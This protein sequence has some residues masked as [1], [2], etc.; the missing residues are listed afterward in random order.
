M[1]GGEGSFMKL[2]YNRTIL[3]DKAQ[4]FLS[5][6]LEIW[7]NSMSYEPTAMLSNT[8][9]DATCGICAGN[10]AL[11]TKKDSREGT[12][13][14]YCGASG[15]SQ[16]IAYALTH[17]VFKQ[18]VALNDLKKQKRLKVVGLSDGP[19]YAK[20]LA[21]KCDYTNTYYHTEPFLDITKPGRKYI[22]RY[23]ALIS[24]D[25]FEHVL[26]APSYAFQG[27]YDILKPGGYLILTVPF[28][29][30]GPH[31]EHYPGLI[32]YT[33]EQCT[34][35]SWVAHLEYA[36]GRKVTDEKPC[37]HG[38]AGKTLEVRL[39]NRTRIEEELA[40]AGFKAVIIHVENMPERGMNWNTASRLIVAR[41]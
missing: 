28:I 30:A 11:N 34:D 4:K 21:K 32:N 20:T 5:D 31:K 15:R 2:L 17:Y 37:F 22:G 13:C 23:D 1:S 27:A 10:Y 29:N 24:A 7:E 33:S 12:L 8:T 36:G 9:V 6:N 40:W 35:G 14:I 41:K 26:A 38:G 3:H 18:E 25:V 16:S 19:A 39:F